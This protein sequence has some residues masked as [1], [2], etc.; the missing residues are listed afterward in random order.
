[1]EDLRLK[2]RERKQ[3]ESEKGA[4]EYMA[5]LR[6]NI[7][8]LTIAYAQYDNFIRL[9]ANK[10]G[11]EDVGKMEE[12]ERLHMIETCNQIRVYCHVIHVQI[13]SIM[14]G[15]KAPMLVRKEELDAKL[16]KVLDKYIIEI[17]ALKDFVMEI[18]HVLTTDFI[19]RLMQ[20]SE[21]ILN[22]VYTE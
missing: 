8:N 20:T 6:E 15:T 3:D 12:S 19:R 5:E 13:I 22:A 21:D 14:Q 9:V 18:N 11:R 2:E 16:V 1:M 10:Y 4:A 17:A 7:R